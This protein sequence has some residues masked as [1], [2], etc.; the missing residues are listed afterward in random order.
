MKKENQKYFLFGILFSVVVL[1]IV[2][3][4]TAVGFHTANEILSGTFTGNYNYSGNV[5]FNGNVSGISSIESGMIIEFDSDNCP[6]GWTTLPGTYSTDVTTGGSASA[7]SIISAP[8]PAT[9]AFNNVYGSASTEWS[10]WHSG[11]GIPQW[12]QYNFGSNSKQISKYSLLPKYDNGYYPQAWE[13]QAYDG[14]TWIA[15]DSQSGQ[16][17]TANEIREFTFYNNNN[18]SR[19]RLY[20]TQSDSGY[21]AID[22]FDMMERLTLKCKKN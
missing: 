15:L 13:F 17:S 20:V 8:H 11:A 21:V 7:S 22:E 9:N 14:S 12:I 6:N 19:Y 1:G 10:M 18:Y 3:T 4:L 2:G 5:N 16:T